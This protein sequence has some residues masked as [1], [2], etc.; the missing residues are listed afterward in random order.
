M[1]VAGDAVR[2][3]RLSQLFRTRTRRRLVIYHFMYGKNQTLP[4]PM[5]TIDGFN[6]IASHLAQNIDVSW[7]G[8]AVFGHVA[9]SI[10]SGG[11]YE[12]SG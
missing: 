4:Y 7:R 11:G 2:P 6:G 9:C 8:S 5:C 12:E 10:V 3:V 1:R